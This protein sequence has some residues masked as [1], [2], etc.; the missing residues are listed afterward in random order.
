MIHHGFSLQSPPQWEY[1]KQLKRLLWFFLTA[2]G[3]FIL[4]GEC[5]FCDS[6]L[7]IQNATAEDSG[8]YSCSASNGPGQ[9][10][11]LVKVAN[12]TLINGNKPHS[13]FEIYLLW[14]VLCSMLLCVS[15]CASTAWFW[16]FV[17]ITCWMIGW[18]ISRC[19]LFSA[20]TIKNMFSNEK[21]NCID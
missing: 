14:F 18:I 13:A 2:K 4:Q 3:R 19:I 10:F 11:F 5:S 17:P 6:I 16:W 8:N 12:G 1:C 9:Q 20:N 7:V 15:K 21:I